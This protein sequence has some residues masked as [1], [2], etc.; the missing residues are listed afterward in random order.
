MPAESILYDHEYCTHFLRHRGTHTTG[1]ALAESVL[2]ISW[3]VLRVGVG[4]IRVDRECGKHSRGTRV[5][6]SRNSCEIRVS[7]NRPAGLYT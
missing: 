3:V 4:M 7:E 6:G 1:E 5:W 2:V